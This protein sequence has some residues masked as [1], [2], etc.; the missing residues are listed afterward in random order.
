MNA[1]Q[2]NASLAA[3]FELVDTNVTKS[4]TYNIYKLPNVPHA[5]VSVMAPTK[6]TKNNANHVTVTFAMEYDDREGVIFQIGDT[7]HLPEGQ[8]M[9]EKLKSPEGKVYA[10]VGKFFNDD[11]ATFMNHVLTFA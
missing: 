3:K 5:F 1:A 8:A 7:M 2:A 4:V 9:A 11:V 6:V 10:S